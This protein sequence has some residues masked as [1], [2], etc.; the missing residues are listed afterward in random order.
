MYVHRYSRTE[1]LWEV[2]YIGSDGEFHVIRDCGTNDEAAAFINYLNGGNG[3]P[4][5]WEKA[6]G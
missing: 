1:R 2:G 3:N 6:N 4:F 5:D